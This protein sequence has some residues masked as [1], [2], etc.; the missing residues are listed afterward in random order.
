[1]SNTEPVKSAAAIDRRLLRLDPRDN[2]V[3]A[4]IAIQKG[5]VLQLDDGPAVVPCEVPLGHKLAAR[6]IQPGEKIIKYGVPIGT[7]TLPI[8]TAEHVHTQNLKSDYLPTYTYDKS[9]SFLAH[10]A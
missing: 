8:A 4:V 3:T 5:S 10:H 1:M 9:D 2:V 7:A 6:A